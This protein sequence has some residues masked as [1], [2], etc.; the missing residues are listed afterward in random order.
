[1]PAEVDRAQRIDDLLKLLG[2]LLV[3]VF[4]SHAAREAEM[5][6]L[7]QQR[8]M[9][10]RSPEPCRHR[11]AAPSPRGTD[12][13]ARRQVVRDIARRLVVKIRRINPH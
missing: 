5:A 12:P 6:F 13:G 8:G 1:M 10:E 4:R 3:G 2:G 9:P 7:R 11:S